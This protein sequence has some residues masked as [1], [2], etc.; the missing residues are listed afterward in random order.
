[1]VTAEETI[2]P[3]EVKPGVKGKLVL[4]KAPGGEFYV[5]TDNQDPKW[6]PKYV[7]HLERR[8]RE[9]TAPPASNSFWWG[10]SGILWAMKD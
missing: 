4:L 7:S 10:Y 6:K 1:M 2:I 5:D 8:H 9:K 3:L